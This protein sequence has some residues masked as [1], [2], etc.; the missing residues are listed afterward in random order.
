MITRA[1]E[2]AIDREIASTAAYLTKLRMAKR[3]LWRSQMSEKQERVRDAYI[4]NRVSVAVIAERFGTSPG[5]INR[6]AVKF[7]WPR[8]S[9]PKV[10]AQRRRFAD[11][12]TSTPKEAA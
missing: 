5:A 3:S 6:W 9:A 11:V 7:G 12:H 2:Q 4:A 10:E 1:E 8:R